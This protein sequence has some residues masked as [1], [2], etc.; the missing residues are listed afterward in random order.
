MMLK[1]VIAMNSYDGKIMI[2]MNICDGKY[3]DRNK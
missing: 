1:I 2:V 3:N